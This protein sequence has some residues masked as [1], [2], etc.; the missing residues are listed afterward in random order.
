MS[1]GDDTDSSGI[2]VDDSGMSVV[3]VT[4]SQTSN[5]PWLFILAIGVALYFGGAFN[6]A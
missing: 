5:F 2:S 4:A 1:F 3:T 6:E